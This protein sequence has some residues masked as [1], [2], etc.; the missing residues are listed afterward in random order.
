MSVFHLFL[1]FALLCFGADETTVSTTTPTSEA[2]LLRQAASGDSFLAERMPSKI[3]G[4]KASMV[5]ASGYG[6]LAIDS[7]DDSSVLAWGLFE[8]RAFLDPRRIA[9]GATTNGNK[10]SSRVVA[11][12]G[13]G[14]HALALTSDG[15][16]WSFGRNEQ[17]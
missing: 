11:I 6:S 17:V 1:L 8:G 7:D 16:V 5:A 13:G 9:I 2:D 3:M 4:L 15:Q 14:Y 10:A 12:A